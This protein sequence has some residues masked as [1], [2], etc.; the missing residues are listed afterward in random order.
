MR[1]IAGGQQTGG[2]AV[3]AAVATP[4]AL[5]TNDAAG[6]GEGTSTVTAAP[7]P[8]PTRRSS[9]GSTRPGPGTRGS[10]TGANRSVLVAATSAT[11]RSPLASTSSSST[12]QTATTTLNT[13]APPRVG[14]DPR[15]GKMGSWSRAAAERLRKTEAAPR[16]PAATT[17]R[18]TRTKKELAKALAK[19]EMTRARDVDEDDSPNLSCTKNGMHIYVY[20][21]LGSHFNVLD[22]SIPFRSCK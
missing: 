1:I 6:T 17:A 2:G 18:N 16:F 8:A 4:P 5:V 21:T 10:S 13:S 20:I 19:C 14:R 11:N 22:Y 7:P 3:T 15:L 12:G 9:A